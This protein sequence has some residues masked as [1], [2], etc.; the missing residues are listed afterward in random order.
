MAT[1]CERAEDD[2]FER[3]DLSLTA[4]ESGA[5]PD[6]LFSYWRTVVPEPSARRKLLV[7]DQVLLELFERLADHDQ[8]QRI[9]F[10]FVLALILLRKKQLKFVG[11]VG[12]GEQEQWLMR[13]R[14]AAPDQ[15][16]L[17]VI[18]PHLEEDDVRELSGQLSEILQSTL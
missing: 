13:P 4:W 6:G 16:P 18:N 15:S 10:R 11:R 9:A 7:D 2:G 12:E 1:L 3:I 5:R 8:P 17:P 14:G